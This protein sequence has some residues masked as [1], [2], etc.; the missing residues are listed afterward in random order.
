[1]SSTLPGVSSIN[2]LSL[3]ASFDYNITVLSIFPE[4]FPS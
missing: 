4:L 3:K 2:I 1:L